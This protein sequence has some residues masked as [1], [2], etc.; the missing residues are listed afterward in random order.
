MNKV[1][2]LRYRLRVIG[3][4]RKMDL[5]IDRPISQNITLAGINR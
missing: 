3:E 5:Y 2:C 1:I 4:E